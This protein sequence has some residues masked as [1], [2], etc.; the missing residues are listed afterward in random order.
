MLHARVVDV[1][2][3]STIGGR[4]HERLPLVDSE[5]PTL[6]RRRDDI[7]LRV[8]HI[9]EPQSIIQNAA[10]IER[11]GVPRAGRARHRHLALVVQD[12]PVRYGRV[13]I[14]R[15]EHLHRIE[16]RRKVIVVGTRHDG[17]V[18]REV[19]RHLDVGGTLLQLVPTPS[20]A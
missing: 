17:C 19:D 10:D 13:Q 7:G 1:L 18:R 12:G 2:A 15:P 8:I 11:K 9:S 4:R 20:Q 5:H 16:Q 14:D 3:P 6:R